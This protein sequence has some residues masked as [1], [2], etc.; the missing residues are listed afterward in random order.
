[1]KQTLALPLLLLLWFGFPLHGFSD[2]REEL[3]KLT[4][5]DLLPR[6]QEE[7]AVRQISSYD[8][9][10]GN[11]DGFSG[12]FSYLRKEADGFVI[13]DLRG[14]GVIQRLWTPTPTGDTIQFFFDGEKL[15]R[16]ELKFSDLFSGK[17]YPFLRPVVG[18]EIGGYYSYLPI[19]YAKGCIIKYKGERMQFIQIQ[20]REITG[21]EEVT[22]FPSSLSEGEKEALAYAVEFWKLAG[23]LLTDK[24]PALHGEVRSAEIRVSLQPG[25]SKPLFRRN[26]GGRIVGLEI[27]PLQPLNERFSD[28]ILKARWNREAIPAIYSPLG[29]FFGYSF[30]KP[31][32]ESLLAGV[33]RGIHYS[34]LPMPY[35]K[36]ALLELDYLKNDRFAQG[37]M[38]FSVTV[39]YTDDKRKPDEGKFYAEWKRTIGPPLGQPVTLLNKKGKGHHVGTLLQAQ[40]LNPG[41]TLFFE[42]DDR[43]TVDGELRLHGT[44]SEDY[45]NGGWYALPDRWDQAFSLPLHGSLSYSVPLART[46]GYRFLMT[47]KIS[48]GKEIDLTIEHGPENNNIPVDYTSLAFY[49]CDRPP[50]SNLAPEEKHL[51]KPA[52]PATMEYW[53]QLLPVKALAM[54][55]TLSHTRSGDE[56]D[57]NRRDIFLIKSEKSGFAKFEL[58]VPSDGEYKLYISYFKGP[59]CGPFSVYQR[60]IPVKEHSDAYAP[61]ENFIEKEYAGILNIKEGTNTITIHLEENQRNSDGNSFMLHRIYLEKNP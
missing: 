35:D 3:L 19:P 6:F 4:R 10:G 36:S 17:R 45:F 32:M 47:D 34:Y 25:E 44:G 12:R 48:F 9:T 16:L 27:R 40:G 59:A 21:S 15:P 56:K 41:M 11:D 1:M 49:Y 13:A 20:Y 18:N 28:I 46:G 50:R 55:T 14:K 54:G 37:E 8:T 60:Q 39:F 42:G 33:S 26:R 58:E 2:Y 51:E 24:L 61:E 5:I 31:A 52:I 30:G 53:I 38:T 7:A 23:N 43:C 22:S 29:D 57:H